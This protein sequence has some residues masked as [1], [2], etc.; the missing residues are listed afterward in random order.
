VH[1][2][3]RLLQGNDLRDG[4]RLRRNVRCEHAGSDRSRRV[5]RDRWRQ[6]DWRR[7]RDRRDA[8]YR[9]HGRDQ[10]DGWCSWKLCGLRPNVRNPGRLLQR[11]ALFGGREVRIHH[12]LS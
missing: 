11:S 9:G 12:S 6:R 3:R 2:D 7:R 5:R 8:R 4:R 1:D 10:R